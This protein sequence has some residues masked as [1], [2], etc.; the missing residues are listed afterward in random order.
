MSGGGVSL[1]LS[2]E[3]TAVK[4]AFR[5]LVPFLM[6]IYVIA[7]IDR[8]NIGIAGLTMNQELALTATMFGFAN[9]AFYFTYA[10]CQVPS[11]M[12]LEHYGAR[13]YIPFIMVAWG[14]AS[15]ATVF[16]TGPYS[17]YG[18]R[19]L[20]G[21]FQAGVLPGIL[22][23]IGLWFPKTYRARANAVFLAAL[24]VSLMIGSPLSTLILGM[25]G[26]WGMSGWRWLFL[27]EALPAV[28]LGFIA[29]LL[30]PARP[31]NASWLSDAE[32]LALQE[33]LDEEYKA[34]PQKGAETITVWQKLANVNVLMLGVGYFCLAASLNTLAVW[35][36]QIVKA[37]LGESPSLLSVGLVSAIPPAAALV[38][39]P[40]IT[41]S[42]DRAK[43]RFG[44]SMAL[45]TL[46]AIGWVIAATV[47]IIPLKILG[48]VFVSIAAYSLFPVYF[49]M[50]SQILPAKGQAVGIAAISMIGLFATI[51]S[52]SF[53][54]FLRDL[55]HNFNAGLWYAGILM[56]VGNGAVL[57]M[58]H[59]HGKGA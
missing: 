18:I 10:F 36:P 1:P 38:M 6:L 57:F 53:I 22:F 5:R 24:P 7:Y 30:L 25:D 48:L 16:A 23:Y 3:E 28:V 43:E 54:G 14:L 46:G 58:R 40:F 47:P 31:A 2:A 26:I 9:T 17:L 21:V 15:A 55:T 37:A 35:M 51:L 42:S 29:P 41:R 4:K 52:P 50:A 11:N 39:M 33:K 32:K 12:M 45:F 13:R 44:H 49:A 8:I 20:F 34:K 56:L 59:R 19:A 27:I